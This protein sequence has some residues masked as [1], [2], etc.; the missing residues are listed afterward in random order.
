MDNDRVTRRLK[1]SQELKGVIALATKQKQR[2]AGMQMAEETSNS[3]PTGITQRETHVL[4]VML[5]V[6]AG[7]SSAS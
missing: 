5:N 6:P 7:T 3:A 2:M 4:S 1:V